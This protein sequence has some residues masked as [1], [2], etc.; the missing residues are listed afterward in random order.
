MVVV[1]RE[2]L[3]LRPSVSLQKK[4]GLKSL[5][6]VIRW[7]DRVNKELRRL[8]KLEDRKCWRA[9]ASRIRKKEGRIS[10]GGAFVLSE[11]QAIVKLEQQERAHQRAAA[12]VR[13]WWLEALEEVEVIIQ[14]EEKLI[15]WRAEDQKKRQQEQAVLEALSG[16]QGNSE[17]R[18]ECLVQWWQRRAQLVRAIKKKEDLKKCGGAVRERR[19]R[20]SRRPSTCPR[21]RTSGGAPGRHAGAAGCCASS[22]SSRGRSSWR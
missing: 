17:E 18:E 8:R 6:Q 10:R 14:P 21:S 9:R 12:K 13:K 19:G 1:L 20:C 7:G 22:P 2:Q 4:V 11:A 5:E 3:D 16:P 15:L